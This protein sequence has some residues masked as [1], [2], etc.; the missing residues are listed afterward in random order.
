MTKNLL[1]YLNELE[2]WLTN[3]VNEVHAQGVVVGLSGGV[4]SAVV[5]AMAK[6]LFP[7]NH[8]TLVMHI[9]NSELDHKATTALVEQLQLNNKQVDLEPPYR[10]MLQ[11]LTIDPQ[12]ELMVA[13]NLKARLRMA[14]LY[15]HAQKHNYLVLGTGNFIEYSL[16]YFTKW[17]DGACDVAPLAFL[18]K[19][20]VYALSQHFNVPELVIERAPTASLFAGQTDEAEM[21]LTYKELDQ[22]FQ[23]HLQLSATKQQRVDHLR[24][25]SQH[26]RSLPK[27]FKPL[28]SF[29]I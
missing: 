25:S 4:D 7:Q 14:C 12:K 24:Q 2:A 3:Y 28:Y 22:Y 11:A 21:G 29:Q 26:K 18:L 27:T 16:G 8:L 10:A 23:G 20:D 6:K 13:G 15:T 5:A 9:N 17:G 1:N 19:S